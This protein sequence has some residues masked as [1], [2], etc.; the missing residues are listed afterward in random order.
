MLIPNT[1]TE[2]N[3]SALNKDVLSSYISERLVSVYLEQISWLV[4]IDDVIAN[5]NP[6][7]DCENIESLIKQKGNIEKNMVNLE[8]KIL[9]FNTLLEKINEE[10]SSIGDR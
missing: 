1:T 10:T 4:G 8:K 2:I 5:N 6:D 3:F 7:E 9:F